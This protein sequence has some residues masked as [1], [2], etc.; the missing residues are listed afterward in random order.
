MW[1][2]LMWNFSAA[3][4]VRDVDG[5][6]MLVFIARTLWGQGKVFRVD[7]REDTD[8]HGGNQEFRGHPRFSAL[9]LSIF[10]FVSDIYL[11]IVLISESILKMAVCLVGLVFQS[12]SAYCSCLSIY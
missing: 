12:H 6:D 5:G 1:A 8:R 11:F 7:P 2:E 4:G 10:I 9:F 3:G